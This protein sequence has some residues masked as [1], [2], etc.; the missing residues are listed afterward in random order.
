VGWRDVSRGLPLVLFLML[1]AVPVLYSPDR[2]PASIRPLFDLNPMAHLVDAFRAAVLGTHAPDLVGL[3][4]LAALGVFTL[5]IAQRLFSV[6]DGVLA[7][8]I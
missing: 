2:V 3:G 6:F 1:Y 4:V 8:V 5:L 7:D